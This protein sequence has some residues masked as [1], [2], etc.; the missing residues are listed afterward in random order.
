MRT[1]TA[2][3]L[4]GALFLVLPLGAREEI[5]EFRSVVDVQESGDLLVEETITVRAE[6]R[7]IKRGIFREFPTEYKERF[8]LRRKVG[9]EVL[10]VLR[11]G[12][13]EPWV[14]NALQN[15]MRVYIGKEDVL[16]AP[17]VYSYTIR[18]RTNRQIATGED[19]DELYWNV[20][21]NGWAFP[22]LRSVARIQLPGRAEVTSAK[23]FTGPQG[24][25]ENDWK[26]VSE[27]PG[28]VEMETTAELAPGEGFTISVQW[29]KGYVDVDANPRNLQ[30]LLQDNLLTFVA[31]AAFLLL[32]TYYLCAWVVLGRDPPRGVIVPLY[33][34]PPGFTPAAV[35]F[36]AGMGTLDDKSFSAAVIQLAVSGALVIRKEGSTYTLEKTA[37]EVEGL[38]PGQ[39]AFRDALF[40][41]GNTLKFESTNSSR[42][43]KAKAALKQWL[44]NDFEKGYFVRNVGVWF[45]GILLSLVPA[46]LALLDASEPMLA[47]FLVLWLSVWTA[48][49]SALLSSA[50]SA[51]T[52]GN[53]LAAIPRI[54]FALPF[55]AAWVFGAFFLF[56]A[57]SAWA[58]SIFVAGAALNLVFYHLLKAPTLAGREIMDR[59]EGFRHYLGV[60]ESERL[61]LENPPERTPVLFEKFLPYAVALDVEQKWAEQFTEILRG[62]EYQPGWYSGSGFSRTNP[63][64]FS[65]SM[66]SGMSSAISSASTAPGSGSG[67][68]GSSGGG[69]GGGGGGGW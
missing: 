53:Y 26:I 32:L 57:T 22:I 58:S 12:R 50:L 49:V 52:S 42:M 7:E 43:L 69:G 14:T 17:G 34:P 66:G 2:I 24:V 23:G 27:S 16:L 3:L 20:T 30:T 21:G 33:E 25:A 68:G 36:V 44:E 54:L 15:G 9:F 5:R 28:V 46:G 48:G 39:V 41:G 63:A 61:N 18:Y 45:F 40:L 4:L 62:S 31:F 8:G 19:A 47:G 38:L 60:A 59:I 29:P 13:P 11:D 55:L 37:G 65:S 56:T 1:H 35:R 64:A 51:W 6:G 10:E 67:G